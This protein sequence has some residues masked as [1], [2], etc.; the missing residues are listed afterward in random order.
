MR[1]FLLS[2][3]QPKNA[4]INPPPQFGNILSAPR[5]HPPCLPSRGIEFFHTIFSNNS[6]YKCQNFTNFKLRSTTEQMPALDPL[7]IGADME[8]RDTVSEP[9][10]LIISRPDQCMDSIKV[11]I[12]V[13]TYI[14]KY[15]LQLKSLN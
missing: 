11:T 3:A 4:I 5:A 12:T 6:T 2:E 7:K 10:S 15:R 9:G 8:G 1:P 13:C 14:P